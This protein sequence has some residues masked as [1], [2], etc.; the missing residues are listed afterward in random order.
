MPDIV[1]IHFKGRPIYIQRKAARAGAILIT[2]RGWITK[3]ADVI[4]DSIVSRMRATNPQS[5]TA[6]EKWFGTQ[7]DPYDDDARTTWVL[8]GLLGE[9]LKVLKDVTMDPVAGTMDD[10]SPGGVKFAVSKN[11]S[12]PQYRLETSQGNIATY[13]PIIGGIVAKAYR[14]LDEYY[15]EDVSHMDP[16]ERA[17]HIKRLI[18]AQDLF[19]HIRDP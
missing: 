12:V 3:N 8:Q 1:R 2:D 9:T 17:N 19:I 5:Q 13:A 4:V 14:D 16:T 15:G 6:G 7:I 10:G 18:L 11:R